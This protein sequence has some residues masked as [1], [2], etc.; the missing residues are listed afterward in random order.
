MPRSQP[1]ESLS[2]F[3]A[4]ERLSSSRRRPSRGEEEE[5]SRRDPGGREPTP[6][7]SKTGSHY[8]HGEHGK[9]LA[10]A[11]VVKQQCPRGLCKGE[12]AGIRGFGCG[13]HRIVSF[14]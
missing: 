5:G 13:I 11:K 3:G 14:R 6:V 2:R 12:P 9:D 1:R 10:V 4:R 8:Y 7:Q